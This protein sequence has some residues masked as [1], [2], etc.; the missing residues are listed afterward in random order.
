MDLVADLKPS[1]MRFAGGSNL[2]G[3]DAPSHWR[4]NDTIGPLNQRRGYAGA[5]QYENTNGLGIFIILLTQALMFLHFC[6]VAF[7][8][9][10]GF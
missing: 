7:V 8:Y 3:L 10:L 9:A 6:M 4:W 5:W 1:F 2:L